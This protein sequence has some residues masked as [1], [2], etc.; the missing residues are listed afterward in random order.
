MINEN[1][2]LSRAEVTKVLRETERLIMLAVID[3]HDLTDAFLRLR[4]TI[5]QQERDHNKLCPSWA[6]PKPFTDCVNYFIIYNIAEALQ[7]VGH[8]KTIPV[9]ALN[10]RSDRLFAFKLIANI[11]E[12]EYWRDEIILSSDLK[13][14]IKRC[15][16]SIDYCDL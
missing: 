2:K 10:Q 1:K 3:F 8:R 4:E 7:T 13:R 14:R 6:T 15:A 11:R 5:V 12:R 9:K 16:E